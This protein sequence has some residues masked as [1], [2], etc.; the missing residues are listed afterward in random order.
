MNKKTIILIIAIALI[1]AA[2]YFFFLK[3]PKTGNST[4]TG[5]QSNTS[6]VTSSGLISVGANTLL[7]KGDKNLE[8]LQLQKY[9]NQRVKP[10]CNNCVSLS[11]DGVFGTKTEN[12]VQFVTGSK[13]TSLNNFKNIVDMLP[14]SFFN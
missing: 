14:T 1:A 2:I 10:Y 5:Q 13:T 7:K 8:V 9:Y 3:T 11:T 6:P 12:A 4:T